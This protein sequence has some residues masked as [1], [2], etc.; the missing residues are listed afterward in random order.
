MSE[1]AKREE[2]RHVARILVA[3]ATGET[4][5]RVVARLGER[6]HTV[7]VLCR[8]LEKA[9]ALFGERVSYH[10]GD[11]RD[12]A[13]LLGAADEIDVAIAALGS[14][15][16]FGQNGGAAVDELGTRQL[17][18]ELGRAGSVEQLVFLS[19]FGLDR[20]SPFLWAFS[21]IFNRYFHWKEQAE[22]AVRA[23]GVPYTIVR[24]VEFRNSP[25]RGMAWLNQGQPLTLLR[26]ISRDT[27]AEVLVGCIR[28][29]EA[30]GKTFELCE[31]TG[32]GAP[33][34]TPSLREQLASM[35]VDA[36]RPRPERTPLF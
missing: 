10:V 7:R 2:A 32:R 16:Y 18:A 20:R 17:V 23:S 27:V 28:E 22:R 36:E 11:V 14:R 6:G 34:P 30:L 15:S 25:P 29:P 1:S 19:A 33:S 13:S 12:A 5:R 8:N 4:G 26:T 31:A 35:R 3:G 21:T 24:P 9:R